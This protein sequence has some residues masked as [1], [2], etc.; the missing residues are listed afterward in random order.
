MDS[1]LL[2]MESQIMEGTDCQCNCQATKDLKK[3]L[4]VNQHWQSDYNQL[5]D[6]NQLLKTKYWNLKQKYED[7]KKENVELMG[8]CAELCRKKIDQQFPQVE[9]KPVEKTVETSKFTADDLEALKQQL[10]IYKQDFMEEKKE[11]QNTSRQ[12][13]KLKM[14]LRQ[15]RQTVDGYFKDN[16]SMKEKYHKLYAEKNHIVNELQR[17]SNPYHQAMHYGNQYGRRPIIESYTLKPPVLWS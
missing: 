7:M 16:Q 11:H 2:S 3:V 9:N 6:A 8:R 10:A 1:M 17:L 15:L 12:N 4:D 13:N 14:E 5:M